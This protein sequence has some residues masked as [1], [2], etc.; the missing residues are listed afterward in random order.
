VERSDLILTGERCEYGCPHSGCE[1]EMSLIARAQVHATLA[2][3]AAT[4]AGSRMNPLAR[5]EWERA[6]GARQRPVISPYP[7]TCPDCGVLPADLHTLKCGVRASGQ[8]IWPGTHDMTPDA[9][10]TDAPDEP[11]A[12]RCPETSD[13]LHCTGWQ[14]GIH[15]CCACGPAPDDEPGSEPAEHDPGPEAGDEGGMSEYR[16]ILPEDYQRGQS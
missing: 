10:I 1:H 5:D 11:R 8:Q 9:M 7:G 14:E 16:Y 13:G 3:A 2:L 6:T 12:A 4:V 15:R